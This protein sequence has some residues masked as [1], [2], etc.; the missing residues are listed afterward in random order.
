MSLAVV[1]KPGYNLYKYQLNKKIGGGHFG[2]VWIAHDI[3]LS[4]DIAV[5]ILDE[6]MAP[7]AENLKEAQVG[8]RLEHQNVVHVHYADVAKVES[9][10]VVIIAMDYHPLGSVVSHLNP[11]NF[12]PITQSVDI[13]IDI[14]RGLEYLHEQTLYHNDIKPSNILLGAKN[15]GVL[16]DYG[17]SCLSVGLQ[18]APAP[19]A[20]VLHRAPETGIHNHIS[21][22]TD[23]YQVGLTLFRLINGLGLI[24]DVRDSVGQE[25]FEELKAQDKVPR[26]QDY[27]PFVPTSVRRIISKATKSDPTSRY[28]SALEMRRALEGVALHGYWTTDSTGANIGYYN[29]QTFRFDCQKKSKGYSFIPYRKRLESG[30]ET[31]IGKLS[32]SAL[33]KSEC[34]KAV[35]DFMLS[36]VNG[37]I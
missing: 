2:E 17:I 11:S 3:T 9:T 19:N 25:K 35:T 16:T 37:E 1:L 26:R 30:K 31:K 33:S 34:D 24:R 14:L 36:V 27:L 28:Q 4:R 6:S 5:K 23:I 12:L 15:E 7:V 32:V 29:N 22:Q 10:N 13:I 21:V 20:Y 8:H 18:P